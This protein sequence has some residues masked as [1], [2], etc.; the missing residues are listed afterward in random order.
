MLRAYGAH[1]V[2]RAEEPLLKAGVPLMRRASYA[3]ANQA[4]AYLRREDFRVP[5]SSVLALVGPGNNGGDALFAAAFLAD[6]SID[7]TAVFTGAV[8]AGGMRAAERSGVRMIALEEPTSDSALADLRHGA[9][10]GGIWID[11]LLGIGSTG[12]AREPYATWIRVLD[13]VRFASPAEP[14]I[15]AVDT[16]SGVGVDD[17]SLPGPVLP[18][19][20]TVAMGCA[21]PAHV[22]PPARYACGEVLVV[23]LGFDEALPPKADVMELT[24][25]DVSDLWVVPGITDHKYTRG[26]VGLLTGSDT[27][28]GAAVLGAA[29]ALAAGPGMV[30]YLGTSEHVIQAFPEVVPA[31]GHVQSLVIGSGLDTLDTARSRFDDARAK[32]TPMV[33]DAGAIEL[34]YA[35]NLTGHVVLTPHAG[36]LTAL[37]QA[38]GE[39]VERAEVEARPVWAATRASELTGATVLAK[40]ATDV[41]ACPSGRLYAQG[42]APGWTGTAGAG[43][44]L[45]GLLGTLLAMHADGL[46]EGVPAQLAA[47]AS[48]IHSQAAILASTSY[49]PEFSHGPESSRRSGSSGRRVGRPI[50][51]SEIAASIPDVIERILNE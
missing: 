26:V 9:N 36:E 1:A 49:E 18:A 2:R 31:D 37:L 27:Y 25:A 46:S 3:V 8:H 44:V 16:P 28:P 35:L 17:G 45:A 13:E 47:A 20:L 12:G 14:F 21:K 30:R 43:D 50:R 29:G 5:G 33:L 42:G 4:I 34:A 51:A 38:K 11:G 10:A 23:D 41:V 32:G 40:F 39:D 22:L 48:H 15:I 19:N 7:V 6:R 24:D